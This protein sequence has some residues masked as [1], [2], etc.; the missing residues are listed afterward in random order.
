[1]DQGKKVDPGR[2]ADAALTVETAP[3]QR[4]PKACLLP[5]R[6]RRRRKAG[7]GF[8][9]AL[10]ALAATGLMLGL[11]LLSIA[12]DENSN[13]LRARL[14]EQLETGLGARNS[15]Q[16]GRANVRLSGFEPVFTVEGLTIANQEAG[17][18][19]RLERA[20]LAMSTAIWRLSPEP[21]RIAFEGLAITL[22]AGETTGQVPAPAEIA[23]AIRA[24]LVAL[25]APE[26]GSQG[27]FSKLDAV[28]GRAISI[29]RQQPDGGRIVLQEG[30]EL[31]GRRE[32]EGFVARIGRTGKSGAVEFVVS[33]Q[34]SASGG[35]SIAF[36][37]RPLR[38]EDLTQLFG[39]EVPGLD[40]AVRLSLLGGTD[41]PAAGGRGAVEMR[42]RLAQGRYVAPDPD[43]PPLV[44]DRFEIAL[45]EDPAEPGLKI[46]R[47]ALSIGEM[48][49]ALSGLLLPDPQ[50]PGGYR[51][52]LSADGP[53]FDRPSPAEPVVRL[54]KVS[55]E[56]RIAP[57]FR[58]LSLDRVELVDSTGT[59]SGSALLSLEE[60]GRIDAKLLSEGLDLRRALRLWPISVAPNTRRWV[61]SHAMAGRLLRLD[62]AS[63]LKGQALQDAFNKRP[64]PDDSLALAFD[65]DDLTIRPLLDA[66]PITQ[67]RLVGKV[68]GRRADF[69]LERGQVA[70]KPGEVVNLREA[71]FSIANTAQRPAL[72]EM[73]IPHA[74]SIEG[75][76]SV[77]SAPSLRNVMATAANLQITAGQIEAQAQVE[78]R[79][80]AKPEAGDVK[81]EFKGE[82]RGVGVD[83]IV[84]GE[85][86]E[87][88]SFTLQSKGGVTSLKGDGRISGIAS[89][90][91]FRAEPGKPSSAV[92]RSVMDDQQRARRGFDLRP[93]VTG[94]VGV[95]LTAAMERGQPPDLD[96]ELDLARAKVEGLVPGFLKRPGQ[97]GKASFDLGTAGERMVLRDFDLDL[98]TISAKGQL[99]VAREGGLVRAE[100][101]SLKLSPGD[102]TR[103]TI[104]R[105]TGGGLRIALRG[106]A[107]DLRPFLRGFQSGRV[108]S[109]KSSDLDLDIQS[110]VLVGFNGELLSAADIKAEMRASTLTKL[111]VKGRFG[112][113]PVSVETS[114][115]SE[116]GP[117]LA[118]ESGD[119]GALARFM[120]IYP[121]LVGGRLSGEIVAGP[122]RQRGLLQ[123]RDF[124]IRGEPAL[125][126]YASATENAPVVDGR[127]ILP[128]GTTLSDAVA[129]TKLRA[130]F[131]RRPG[132]LELAEA[133]IWGPQVGASLEGLLDY[134]G[135]RVDLKGAFVPAYA[136]NNLFAQVPLIGPLL[137]G[138]Q[139]EGLFAV[140]FLI[141]G[142]AS[143]PVL[144]T[145]PISVIAPGFLR[146]F[147]EIQ[148]E[149]ATGA[150]PARPVPNVR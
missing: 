5:G 105:R 67:G 145:N 117:T 106:N 89:Q 140:P 110:T 101:A 49:V 41:V 15:V 33:S 85:N 35:Q 27:L 17:G 99:E 128:R 123:V 107:F 36:E 92:I 76:M 142:K 103:A 95:T 24:F 74:G 63:S 56:G 50:A 80:V 78:L 18:E 26:S 54:E 29:A 3:S 96:I 60:G 58:T 71:T 91:D 22:P 57:G 66:A 73:S 4:D 77:L 34:P 21:R 112:S 113:A 148:R 16:L 139:Y 12:G 52:A 147:F 111:A 108:D 97:P 20:D 124:V 72:L 125:R 121:R 64:V 127:P 55:I 126:Q 53:A 13:F 69:R 118:I 43:I 149:G 65:V 7:K 70:A 141:S 11:L 23:A 25:A 132:R 135:D 93:A 90:I 28:S 82:L 51:I 146:K 116:G 40:P 137:G 39:V 129:F 68:S 59:A 120:D 2:K 87:A 136:L 130:Q 10:A 14:I 83:N 138:S 8:L 44:I 102:N 61:I 144:R 94:P 30:L 131:E 6:R 46:N 86:L 114:G 48:D 32:A 19:A 81:V 75:L 104:E 62:I 119:A 31:D 37:T 150:L 109:G 9:A 122:G 47:L 42:V 133:V 134:A 79:L 98:G 45:A 143:Q 100:L 88:G 115:R 84:K 38:K 1:M